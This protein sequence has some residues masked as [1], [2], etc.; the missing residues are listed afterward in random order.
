MQAEA[1]DAKDAAQLPHLSKDAA[2]LPHLLPPCNSD[3]TIL[4]PAEDTEDEDVVATMD[5]VVPPLL[6]RSL[7]E[8]HPHSWDRP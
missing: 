8:G 2:Q 6:F 5:E 3:A 1:S 7:R 4:E